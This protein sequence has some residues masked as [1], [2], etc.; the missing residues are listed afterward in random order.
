MKEKMDCHRTLKITKILSYGGLGLM[1]FGIVIGAAA[2]SDVLMA[3]LGI[4]GVC[5][6]VAGLVLGN[7]YVRCPACGSSL[8]L[9]GCIPNCLPKRCP[10]CGEKI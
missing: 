9:R 3:V 2:D 8:M 6:F 1:I 10:E 5:D 7:L 4:V